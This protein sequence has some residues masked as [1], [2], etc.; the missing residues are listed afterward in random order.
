[1]VTGGAGFIGSHLV[2]KLV[3]L[4]FFVRVFDNLSYGKLENIQ[5]HLDSGAVEFVKGNITKIKP[6]KKAVQGVDYVFHLAALTSVPLSVKNPSLTF[7]VNVSGTVN[8]L[9]VSSHSK[10]KKLVFASSCAVYGDPVHFPVIEEEPIDPISPYAESKVAGEHFCRGFYKT[11]MLKTVMFRFFNVYGPRQAL[12][13]YSGVITKFI[14]NA[15]ADKSLLVYG[16]GS[17]TRD[18]VCVFDVV[19]ALVSCLDDWKCEG[20]AF[21]VG[22]GKPT[23]IQDLAKTVIELTDSKSKIKNKKEREGDIKY[24]YANIT[25]AKQQLGYK[26]KVSLKAGLKDLIDTVSG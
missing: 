2:D 24:S 22:S 23:K 8:L 9:R 4:G 26:P 11:G 25:K 15:K 6:V 16:D 14:D 3:D 7:N 18:F 1:L 13:D 12:N 5:K 20:E 19:E 17:A 10:V 21:N